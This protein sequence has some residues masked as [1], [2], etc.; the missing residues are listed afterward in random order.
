MLCRTCFSGIPVSAWI[1]ARCEDTR[2]L[3][4]QG[5]TSYKVLL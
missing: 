2:S 4:Y 3:E 1:D 5:S